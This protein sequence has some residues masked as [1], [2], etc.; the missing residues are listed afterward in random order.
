MKRALKWL[1]LLL[2]VLIFVVIVA[3]FWL[4]RTESGLH[5]ALDR[6]L[7]ATGGKL[8]IGT[9]EGSLSGPL[10]LHDVRW[11]DTGVDVQV[12]RVLLDVAPL[13]LLGKVVHV[14][15]LE[16]ADVV[17]LAT[18]QPP[19]AEPPASEP[20]SLQP[21]IDVLLDRLLVERVRVNQDGADVFEA[22]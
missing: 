8:A 1:A 21:P 10:V 22:E 3:A 4:L 18:T 11:R 15:N 2:V 6:A 9:S 16:V 13:A 5:F 20:F 7:A 14:E 19:P 17:V 12:G